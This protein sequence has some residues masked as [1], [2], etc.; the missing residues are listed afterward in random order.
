MGKDC[1]VIL[2]CKEFN[3]YLVKKDGTGRITLRNRKH[4][5]KYTPVP[6][7]PRPEPVQD[8]MFL[9]ATPHTYTLP[10]TP[11]YTPPRTEITPAVHQ[12]HP[13]EVV[14]LGH[15]LDNARDRPTAEGGLLSP[16]PIP[17]GTASYTPQPNTPQP[18]LAAAQS[19]ATPATESLPVQRPE[20][21]R[22]PNVRLNPEE[23]ELG[24]IEDSTQVG[25]IVDLLLELVRR[26]PVDQRGEARGGRR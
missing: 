26:L 14:H 25:T 17:R 4:L 3:Q 18:I 6:K 21:V 7:A 2:E 8:M 23:W 22:L 19:P 24:Q 9:H 11:K 20:R 16:P 1:G 10:P 15:Q 12:P 5:R 13:Q